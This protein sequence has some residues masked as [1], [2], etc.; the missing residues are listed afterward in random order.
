MMRKPCQD[1]KGEA[2]QYF[3]HLFHSTTRHKPVKLFSI[4][5]TSPVYLR[6]VFCFLKH[7]LKI[8]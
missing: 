8:Y 1:F 3:A 6:Q 5:A 2:P 7:T 4:K